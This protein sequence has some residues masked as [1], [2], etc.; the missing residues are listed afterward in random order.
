MLNPDRY[1]TGKEGGREARRKGID[2]QEG[3]I[4]GVERWEGWVGGMYG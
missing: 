3:G 1:F 4:D 2:G